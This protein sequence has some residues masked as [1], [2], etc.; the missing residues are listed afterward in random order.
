M[1]GREL[2]E[3]TKR[4]LEFV[5]ENPGLSFNEISRRLGI[6]KGDLQYHLRKLEKLELVVSKRSG[7]RRHY[8]PSGMFSEREKD[9]LSILAS[10]NMREIIMYLI[11]NP[12]PTQSELCEELGLS[13]SSANYYIGKLGELGLVKS[14]R[15]GKFVRYH[16]TGD[17]DLFIKMIRNYHPS[18]LDRWTDR[19]LDIFL[20]LEGK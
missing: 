12:D 18:L 7:L 8:F 6:A 3:R 13:P 15:D 14:V 5:R 2:N 17:V 11:A 1:K 9:V 4:V 20:E 16:F 19:M 10:E